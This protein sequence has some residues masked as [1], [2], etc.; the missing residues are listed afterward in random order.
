[1]TFLSAALRLYDP[2]CMIL[3]HTFP[4]NTNP[5]QPLCLFFVILIPRPFLL[6]IRSEHVDSSIRFR[7]E[8]LVGLYGYLR[9]NR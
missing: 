2:S 1:M 3:M 7:E 6:Q 4:T 9:L 5:P 8:Q